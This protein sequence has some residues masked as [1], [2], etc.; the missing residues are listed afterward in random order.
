[1]FNLTRGEELTAV[2]AIALVGA[3]TAVVCLV[4]GDKGKTIEVPLNSSQQISV[5][6]RGEGA[7]QK[8]VVPVSGEVEPK[9]ARELPT[10]PRRGLN[11]TAP[12]AD[13]ERIAVPSDRIPPPGA[14]SFARTVAGK[15]NV[16]TASQ[17]ELESLPGIGPTLAGRIIEL[18]PF[19]TVDDLIRVRGIGPSTLEKIRER[20]C[21][22]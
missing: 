21:V 9:G 3:A 15:I 12:P 22:E 2:L 18:R 17:K 11:A 7:R 13:G 16:N 6:D 19:R 4:R 8:T 1:M 5:Q 20:V 10:P 14:T